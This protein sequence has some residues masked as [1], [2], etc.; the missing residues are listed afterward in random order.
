MAHIFSPSGGRG[1]QISE[2]R[3]RYTVSPHVRKQQNK[4][5]TVFRV[6]AGTA[7]WLRA[8]T[9][10]AGDLDEVCSIHLDSSQQPLCSVPEESDTHFWILRIRYSHAHTHTHTHTHTYTHKLRLA[11]MH[12]QTFLSLQIKYSMLPP[13]RIF[14]RDT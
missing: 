6:W 4:N 14:Q 9:T 8:C 1:K 2:V 5:I 12:T 11:S 10:L 13:N 7:Q 3:Q